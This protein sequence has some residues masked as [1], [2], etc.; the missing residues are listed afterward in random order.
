M[1]CRWSLETLSSCGMGWEVEEEEEVLEKRTKNGRRKDV[2]HDR[3]GPWKGGQSR[4]WIFSRRPVFRV[5]YSDDRNLSHDTCSHACGIHAPV[6]FPST[7]SSDAPFRSSCTI[8]KKSHAVEYNKGRIGLSLPPRYPNL[9]RSA[10]NCQPQNDD[11]YRPAAC[12]EGAG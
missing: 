11:A 7:Y 2:I 3:P 6:T 9:R 5:S 12:Q 10:A 1:R 8:N 4:A